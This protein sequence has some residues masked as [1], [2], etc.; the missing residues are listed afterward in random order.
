MIKRPVSISWSAKKDLN[1][2][3]FVKM[4]DDYVC[5]MCGKQFMAKKGLSDHNWAVHEQ[6]ESPCNFCDK[7]FR[8]KKHLA[9]HISNTHAENPR[10]SC[11]FK[12]GEIACIYYSTMKSNLTAHKKRVHEKT[13]DVILPKLVCVVCGYRTNSKFNLDRHSEKCNR[14]LNQNS[15]DH[16][17]NICSKK[18]SS[19][20]ILTKHTK[21][22]NRSKCDTP[23][24]ASSCVVCKKTFVNT[25]NMERHTKKDHG[26]TEKGNVIENSAG[27][28]IF[29]TEA[30]VKEKVSETRAERLL[31]NKWIA[32][33]LLIKIRS[34][35]AFVSL[36]LYM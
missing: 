24:S 15:T 6:V 4:V 5:N 1:T 8:S 34:F 26:L 11:D 32:I 35:S 13:I 12:S 36:N 27:I 3:N 18:F 29:T 2:S 30:L 21:L 33:N 9:V 23:I 17:C 22:H 28:A 25:W 14:S 7:I 10:F 20:K 31:L 16:T 19:K